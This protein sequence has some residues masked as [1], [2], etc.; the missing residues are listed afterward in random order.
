MALLAPYLG[1]L[2][3]GAWVTVQLSGLSLLFST[4]IGIVLGMIATSRLDPARA[5]VR[6]Y[7]EVVR[8]TPLLVLVFFVYFAL[9]V[10]INIRLSPYAAATISFS[11]YGGAYM[12]EVVRSGILSVGRQQWQAARALGIRYGRTMIHIVAPQALAVM[13]PA[14]IGVLIDI[15]KG[16]SIA[17][18]IGFPELLQTST[19]IRNVIYSLSPL[20]AAGFLYFTMCFTLARIGAAVE[21]I[22]SHSH[23]R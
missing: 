1:V 20:F 21:R 9:P 18:I 19:N 22:F 4:M 6:A 13:I 2:M 15:I 14:T 16:S 8:S 5:A 11:F 17:S 3:K 7:V 23:G 12:T 10:V